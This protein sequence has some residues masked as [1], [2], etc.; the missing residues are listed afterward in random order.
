MAVP[1]VMPK[2]GNSVESSIIV[3]WK[4]QVG[5]LVTTGEA[6]CEVETDKATVEV[7]SPASGTLLAH[8]FVAGDDVPVM[9][10]IAAVGQPGEDVSAL[11]PA[12]TSTIPAAVPPSAT[13]GSPP[14]AQPAAVLTTAI[15][16]RARNLAEKRGLPLVDIEG[17]GP[18]GRIIERDIVAALSRQP[19]LT[20]LAQAKIASGEFMAPSQGSGPRGKVT[21]RD[22]V[23]FATATSSSPMPSPDDVEIIPAKGVRKVIA[24]RMLASMQTTAQLTMNTS[25]DSRTLLAL[26][27]RFKASAEDL[28]L[29]NIT[30]NDLV[31]YAVAR[32][33]VAHPNLNS[34][35]KEEAIHQ[36]RTVNLGFAVDT[37][38]GLI[39][40]V[41]HRANTLSL[42]ALA[43][44]TNRLAQAAQNST[45]TPDEMDG[46][47]FTVT[48][49]GSLGIEHFT[50][51]LNPPQVAILG[52]GSVNLKPV[53]VDGEIEHIPHIALSLT[54]NH[55]VVDGAPGARFL[56][57]LSRYLTEIDLLLAL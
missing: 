18:G 23:Q 28:G 21:T 19:R 24:S 30:I 48:N 36:Y 42:H 2:L 35:Y 40:P 56:Q 47:T 50:P 41:V 7:E 39:V 4:K 25:A 8:F 1:V 43:T 37:P 5:D 17:T 34:L 33:L 51:I 6:L 32:T 26:R 9:L 53:E 52:V 49:L 11:S 31:L 3:Q 27:K 10:N 54:I 15:S 46:G 14:A 13:I 20:P 16:P 45:I 29:R 22:L 55:Q 44:E 38:R 57:T 12:D